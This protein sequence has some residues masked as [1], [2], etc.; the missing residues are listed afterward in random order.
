MSLYELI[1]DRTQFQIVLHGLEGRLGLD[2]LDIE[3]PP[4]GGV[5]ST[6]IGA[7]G[8]TSFA[9]PHSAELHDRMPEELEHGSVES[10]FDVDQT[11]RRP[12][13]ATCSTELDRT[14][15]RDRGPWPRISSRR[16][17]WPLE[18]AQAHGAF[19]LNARVALRQ[20]IEFPGGG[21]EARRPRPRG[22]LSRNH[23]QSFPIRRTA[24]QGFQPR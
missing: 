6:R 3:L 16:R 24:P 17:P 2:E 14:V 1:V 4:L 22:R 12:R 18:L 21:A 13:L 9:P 5:L 23:Q 10:H 20:H 11:P 8:M 19:L 15:P 7:Q